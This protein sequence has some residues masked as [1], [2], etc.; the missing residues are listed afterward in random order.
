MPMMTAHDRSGSK[1]NIG[2]ACTLYAARR[3][4]IFQRSLTIGILILTLVASVLI[5]LYWGEAAIDFFSDPIKVRAMV[6]RH[7]VSSRLVFFLANF[8]QVVIA[9]IPGE[10]FELAAGYAF[11]V[12]EGTLICMAAI[13]AASILIFLLVKRFG[14]PVIELFFEP[15]KIDQVRLFRRPGQL[16]ILL[17][18]LLF[19][20]GTPKD[21]LTYLA[22]LTPIRLSSWLIIISARLLSVV[23]STV[24]GGLLGSQ[25]YIYAV[26]VFLVTGLV[27][28]AGILMYNR[29]N[30]RAQEEE[31]TG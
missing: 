10:P 20:P 1:V 12:V 23:T 13:Y 21:I 14:R 29:L 19:L 30:R 11:G 18:I 17:Y 28:L 16:N 27:A 22:G 31:M 7:P 5:Y 26:L 4:R 25:N 9:I 2:H 3:R 24:S 8:M 6:S 15:E